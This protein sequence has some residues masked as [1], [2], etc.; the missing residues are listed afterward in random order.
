MSGRFLAVAAAALFA[1]LFDSGT[2]SAGP[3]GWGYRTESESGQVMIEMSGLTEAELSHPWQGPDGYNHW[4]AVPSPR[5]TG[6]FR[7]YPKYGLRID[8]WRS[9]ATVTITDEASGEQGRFVWWR[10]WQEWNTEFPTG[11]R[12][13]HEGESS[14]PKYTPIWLRLGGNVYHVTPAREEGSMWVSAQAASTPEPG[15]LAMAG[16]GLGAV[17]LVRTRQRRLAG[18]SPRVV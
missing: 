12:T 6:R 17:G 7:S 8:A 10:E 5:Q 14:G 9:E 11:D 18:A 15:T 13:E 3:I 1:L 16:L 2:C 4:L